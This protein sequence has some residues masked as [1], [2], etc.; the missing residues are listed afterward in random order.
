MH[1][2]QKY[3]ILI[4]DYLPYLQLIIQVLEKRLQNK[5]GQKDQQKHK[6]M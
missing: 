6:K 3:L 1:K 5:E 4:L 2:N